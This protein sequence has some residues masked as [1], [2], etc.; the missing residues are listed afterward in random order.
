[1]NATWLGLGIAPLNLP[2]YPPLQIY[3]RNIQIYVGTCL[4]CP[5]RATRRLRKNT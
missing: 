3:G 2:P 4:I 1:M 5:N